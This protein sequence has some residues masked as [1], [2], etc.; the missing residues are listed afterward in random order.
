MTSLNSLEDS[1]VGIALTGSRRYQNDS[2]DDLRARNSI[3][4]IAEALNWSDNSGSSFGNLIPKGAKVLLKPNFVIHENQGPWGIDPLI[5][6]PSLIHSIVDE[7]LQTTAA[8]VL[9]GDAPIQE[10]RFETLLA[11]TGLD[12]WAERVRDKDPRFLGVKD[13]RRTTCEFK[14]GVRVA[15]ENLIS[16]DRF[17]LFDLG[18]E[19]LLEEVTGEENSFRVTCYDP[20]LLAETHQQRRH[21]YLVAREV[22]EADVIINLPKLKTHKKAGITCALKNLIGINGNKEYLPHHRVGGSRDGGDCYPGTSPIK[23]A[24]EYTLDR[25]N[26]A[27]SHASAKL[28]S[29]V[30]GG[31]T[32]I[33][34]LAGDRLGV[35]GSWSGNDTIWRTALD[36]NRI[37]L[38]GREDG[39]IADVPQRRVVHIVDAIIAGQGDGP[40]RPQPFPMGLIFGGANAAAVDW[41]GACLLGYAPANI[42][43]VREAFGDFRWP[44]AKFSAEDVSVAGDLSFDE[45]CSSSVIANTSRNITYPIGWRDAAGVMKCAG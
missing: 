18:A 26:T 35:E 40:L 42:P 32:R 25:Q 28:W 24:L 2:T 33:S 7:V 5:T 19:S 23:H 43:I 41:I 45:V 9:V 21:Q 17:A 36:L 29:Q 30:S 39:G 16:E 13:F 38:Y 27:E 12:E 15:S 44:I 3:A 6:H 31:L 1:T 37:M 11:A 8:E 22:L 14:N 10:C 20:R 4:R 34:N